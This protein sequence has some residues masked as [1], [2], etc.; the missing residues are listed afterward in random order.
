MQFLLIVGSSLLEDRAPTM[1][2][3]SATTICACAG[4]MS[5]RHFWG[6]MP[7]DYGVY[8]PSN[9]PS[10]EAFVW[11]GAMPAG[12][13]R[14]RCGLHA[15]PTARHPGRACTNYHRRRGDRFLA[16]LASS[17][18]PHVPSPRWISRDPPIIGIANGAASLYCR[19]GPCR[20]DQRGAPGRKSRSVVY[21]LHQWRTRWN[22]KTS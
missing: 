9:G 21:R 7:P 5:R 10:K 22:T 16:L 11:Q 2:I 3:G 20:R 14:D 17:P 6:R 18:P 19:P 1:I 4:W 15:T 13:N 8:L 12:V